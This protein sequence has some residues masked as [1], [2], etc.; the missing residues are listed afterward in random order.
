[1][2]ATHLHEGDVGETGLPPRP[3]RLDD[4]VEVGTARDR[5]PATSSGRTNWLAPEK[6]IG[7]GRSALT[8]H[9]PPNQRNCS[10]ARCTAA[11]SEGSQQIGI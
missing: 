8:F 7:V 1:M 9:P 5:L 6:P 2:L 10:W 4:R 3:H 11:S